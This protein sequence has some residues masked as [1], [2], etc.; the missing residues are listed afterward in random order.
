M[1]SRVFKLKLALL[2]MVTAFCLP[3]A[4]ERSVSGSDG[5][6][7][8][9]VRAALPPPGEFFSP[10]NSRT[11]DGKLIPSDQFFP[12][13]RC[14]SCHKDTHAGWSESLH[15]N[16]GREP[17]YKESVDIL[18][19]T[20]GIEFTRHC[21]S[22]H[23]PVSLFSGA[24]TK[25][26]RE[27]RA[28]DDEGVTCTVCHSITDVKL[29]GT[30]S[31]TIRRPALLARADGTPVYGDVPDEA[32]LADVPGHRRA[33][34]RPLLKSAEFCASCHKSVAPPELNGY[35]F[36]RGF[37]T[38][39]EWQQ[40][41]ASHETVTP[42]YR[43]DEQV[44]CRKCHMPPV[45][46]AD[47]KAA[48]DGSI[49][50]HR[51]LG[52]NTATPLFYGQ[53]QQVEQTIEF[54]QDKVLNVDIFAVHR[55][56][57]GERVAALDATAEN[58]IAMTPGEELTAEVV[59]AN[60]KAGHS[61]P[62]EL[63]DMY[64]PWVEFE[65]IDGAG[66]T[67]FH[68]G[69]IK[70]DKTLDESAH[71][72]KS[73]LLDRAGRPL[74]RHQVWLGTIKAYDNFINAGRSDIARFRFRVP[75]EAKAGE[76]V[77][78]TLR[79]RV[80]YRRFIQEYTDRVLE[81]TRTP[82]TIPV[83]KMAEAQVKLGGGASVSTIKVKSLRP[84]AP[85]PER[86]ARRWNDYGIGLLEQSQYGAASEA[87]RRASTLNPKDTDLLVNVSIAEM[88]TEQF[89]LE[90]AQI[91]KASLLLDA[92][93]KL[94]PADARARFFKALVL[95]AEGKTEAAAE[96]LTRIAA[97]YPRDREVRR[98]LGQTLFLLGR[99]ADARVAFEAV[100]A[101]DPNDAG[102]YQFL[103]SIYAGEG[104]AQDA[105]RAQ[106]LY[107]LWRDDP[108][109]DSIA[110]RFFAANPQW[111]EE[112]VWSHSHASDSPVRPTLTGHMAAP[113]R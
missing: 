12:A 61:F 50:S 89:G 81:R 62:P 34:M 30:G 68:S 57:T 73:I 54:L 51:W 100:I 14:A 3:F 83:V 6:R 69:F 92:A 41:G 44:D 45:E 86:E 28:M 32:I 106:K 11:E 24:L 108:L 80:N 40:S 67:V 78:L 43:R 102:A 65:A 33:V 52:A 4:I 97:E 70:P 60:R 18:E 74:T 48:K 59:I 90:R 31:Y 96:S 75:A 66:K 91:R 38:Y 47:D 5:N 107:L 103:S 22:C 101:I 46:S 77:S 56:A 13:S 16:A 1:S 88:R 84:A 35:K 37:S 36:I 23:A 27:S 19:K 98:Q 8:E 110:A 9:E 72:Y 76:G 82:L 10:S 49:I 104:R 111:A 26:S 17:F 112:R 95:R 20:R 105:A 79:A 42:F 2:V 21:E 53:T 85:A 25:G 93:L 71:V 113:V 94:K 99:V 109:T 55:E 7:A 87:F 39:D 29:D 64:E 58:S 63:R 15:R